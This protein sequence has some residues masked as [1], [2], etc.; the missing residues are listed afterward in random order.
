MKI[1]PSRLFLG[2]A[3]LAADGL[4]GTAESQTVATFEKIIT[5]TVRYD[6][7]LSLPDSYDAAS[8]KQWPVILF[9]HGSGERGTDPWKVAVHGPP[10]LIRGPVRPRPSQTGAEVAPETPEAKHD[11]WTETYNN[12]ALYTWLLQHKREAK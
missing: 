11:S 3:A 7:L 4:A 1:S 10:K 6:Y 5:K 8:D 12:P 9:L 2:L